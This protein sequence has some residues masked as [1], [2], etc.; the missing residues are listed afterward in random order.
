RPRDQV[1]ICPPEAVAEGL[2][3]SLKARLD[4]VL[5]RDAGVREQVDTKKRR[6]NPHRNLVREK[7]LASSEHVGASR[8]PQSGGN[9]ITSWLHADTEHPSGCRDSVPLNLCEEQR[10][11]TT[12]SGRSRESPTHYHPRL[13]AQRRPFLFCA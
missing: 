12:C 4:E 8:N 9:V 3:P 5:S 7:Q 1:L 2:N 10:S 11:R 13:G 6:C